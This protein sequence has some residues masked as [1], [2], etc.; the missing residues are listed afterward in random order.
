MTKFKVGDK[1]VP[2]KSTFGFTGNVG[3][4]KKRGYMYDWVVAFE[5]KEGESFDEED[6]VHF[7]EEETVTKEKKFFRGQP[8]LDK[9][10][11]KGVLL[12]DDGTCVSPLYVRY[13]RGSTDYCEYDELEPSDEFTFSQVVAGLEQE[14]FEV[15]TSFQVQGKV[16]HVDC[17]SISGYGLK[18][19]ED[20]VCVNARIGV[21]QINSTWTLVEPRKEMTLEEIEAELGYKIKLKDNGGN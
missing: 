4:I 20:A 16:F 18:E 6:L 9:D 2:T 5:N 10:G 11:Y 13:E 15:G 12:F 19:D 1:V 14:Y 8:V 7:E 17:T 3:T 21:N